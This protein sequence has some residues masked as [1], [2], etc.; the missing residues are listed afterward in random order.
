MK[1]NIG[2][3]SEFQFLFKLLSWC[4]ALWVFSK[5]KKQFI[6]TM[7]K[8]MILIFRLLNITSQEQKFTPEY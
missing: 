4:F 5:S 1:Y 6:N 8:L 3:I 2:C 7:N